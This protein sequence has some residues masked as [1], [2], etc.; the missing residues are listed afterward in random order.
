MW[1][2]CLFE[3]CLIEL[4]KQHGARFDRLMGLESLCSLLC[5]VIAIILWQICSFLATDLLQNLKDHLADPV[6]HNILTN[7]TFGN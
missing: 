3:R 6:H 7:W 5:L 1:S 4:I 2:V